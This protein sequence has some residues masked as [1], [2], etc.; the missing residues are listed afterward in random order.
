MS[1][2]IKA[3]SSAIVE[4]HGRVLLIRRRRPP[5]ADLFAFPGGRAEP[6]EEPYET[7][8]RE[9]HEE[10]GLIGRDPQLFATYD[11]AP[12][13]AASPD[14]FFLSVF[15]VAVDGDAPAVAA[16]DAADAGWY[17]PAEVETL[18]VPDS[19]RDCVRRLSLLR[20]TRT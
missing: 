14:H 1:D 6:G 8:L 2:P 19:V 7:A 18:P 3:A 10:T 15:L 4:R 12:E 17:L 20:D 5:S 11:L 16:T 13:G 9:L